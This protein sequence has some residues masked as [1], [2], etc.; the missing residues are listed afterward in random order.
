M[1]GDNPGPTNVIFLALVQNTKGGRLGLA[2]DKSG[3]RV[4]V[5]NCV[6]NDMYM[7]VG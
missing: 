5:H 4:G 7:V 1:L 2:A 3:A 6:P